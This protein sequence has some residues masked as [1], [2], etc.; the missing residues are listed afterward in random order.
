[1]DLVLSMKHSPSLT[2]LDQGFDGAVLVVVVH[3]EDLIILELS[4][5][6]EKKIKSGALRPDWRYVTMSQA[7]EPQD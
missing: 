4:L 1:M 5:G 7:V 6:Q 2:Y 3:L